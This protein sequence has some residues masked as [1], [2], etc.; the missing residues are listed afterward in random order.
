[1]GLRGEKS[2]RKEA[3][4]QFVLSEKCNAAEVVREGVIE[5]C[6]GFPLAATLRA[7]WIIGRKR[8]VFLC[9][10]RS[11]TVAQLLV[12]DVIRITPQRQTFGSRVLIDAGNHDFD[13]LHRIA[14][15]LA[16]S[17]LDGPMRHACR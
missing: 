11:E 9:F 12:H 15:R 7:C 14:D 1:M 17:F 13:H 6:R 10:Q 5:R 4:S 8:E 2:R 16:G 3:A